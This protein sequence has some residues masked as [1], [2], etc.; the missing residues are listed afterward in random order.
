R[1]RPPGH[2]L[3]PSAMGVPLHGPAAGR[4]CRLSSAGAVALQ[5]PDSTG[6]LIPHARPASTPLAVS[7]AGPTGPAGYESAQHLLHQSL[8]QSPPLS[9]GGQQAGNQ[10][11]GHGSRRTNAGLAYSG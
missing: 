6:L 7:P 3:P 8:Q 10:A 4:L 11:I 5:T 1:R 2:P 9:T